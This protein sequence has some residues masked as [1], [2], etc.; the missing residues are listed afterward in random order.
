MTATCQ[1]LSNADSKRVLHDYLVPAQPSQSIMGVMYV[2]ELSQLFY[3]GGLEGREIIVQCVRLRSQLM[4]L[5]QLFVRGYP[6][7]L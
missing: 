3:Q 6:L 2:S 7:R 4:E 1:I 5:I